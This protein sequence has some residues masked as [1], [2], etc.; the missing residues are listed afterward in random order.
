MKYEVSGI[1]VIET[2]AENEQEARVKVQLILQE[3]GIDGYVIQVKE[4]REG[5]AGSKGFY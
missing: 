4:R 2:E 5:N 3:R 1:F